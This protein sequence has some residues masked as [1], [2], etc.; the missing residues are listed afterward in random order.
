[1][2]HKLHQ[3]IKDRIKPELCNFRVALLFI[4]GLEK[5]KP[6]KLKKQRTFYLK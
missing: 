1:M 6:V 4:V 5:L 3:Q 2:M